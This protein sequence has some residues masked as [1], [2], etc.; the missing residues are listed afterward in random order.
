MVAVF[1]TTE[2]LVPF[3]TVKACEGL[4]VATTVRPKLKGEGEIEIGPY[5]ATLL[6]VAG[7][8]V[9]K[10]LAAVILNEYVPGERLE[11]VIE[12]VVPATV[13]V[14]DVGPTDVI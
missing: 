3:K 6:L 8:P 9:P 11:N 1:M 2:R 13:L 12:S 14:S 10:A 4:F 7:G 5:T